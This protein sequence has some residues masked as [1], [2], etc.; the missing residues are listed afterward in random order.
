MFFFSTNNTSAQNSIYSYCCSPKTVSILVEINTV[1]DPCDDF[2]LHA[3]SPRGSSLLQSLMSLK[4]A[5][6]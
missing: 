2:D 3:K 1:E 5:L 4:E 6:T